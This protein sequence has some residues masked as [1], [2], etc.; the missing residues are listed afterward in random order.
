MYGNN[1]GYYNPTRN[2][3]IP[4]Q[5]INN[6]FMQQPQIPINNYV[7]NI[8]TQNN[9]LGKI[10]D[11]VDVVK[12]TDIPLDGSVSYFPL[13]DGSAIVTKKL[14]ANGTSEIQ[15]YKPVIE[16]QNVEQKE[17]KKYITIEDIE[18]LNKKISKLDNSEVL[19]TLSDEIK[20]LTKEVRELKDIKKA[21][22]K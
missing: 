1:Y 21:K 11:N 22:E 15:V 2:I 16:E 7:P 19:D 17:E 4:Q 20:S 3:A 14:G 6:Q 18:D 10:V 13:T 8:P 12:A 5:P 9:L